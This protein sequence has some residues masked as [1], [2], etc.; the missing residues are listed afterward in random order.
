MSQNSSD[1]DR[2]RGHEGLGRSFDVIASGVG[3]VA[4]SPLLI[5]TALLIQLGTRGPVLFRQERVGRNGVPFV[6]LKFC[7][8]RQAE[9]GPAVTVSGD[10][11]VTGVG[12]FLR[13]FKLDELPQ[14]W[15]I[16][17][18]EMSVVG[19]RPEVPSY[20]DLRS[21][22]WVRVLSVSPGL[23]DP[24]TIVLRDEEGVLAAVDDP[25]TFYRE[26][27]LPFKLRFYE[28]YL[29]DRTRRSDLEVLWKTLLA[30]LLPDR[31]PGTSPTELIAAVKDHD[32]EMDRR[33]RPSDVRP[34][35]PG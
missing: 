7:S 21:P 27:L 17:R 32:P 28:S 3:L 4:L 8:M 15:N 25:E 9:R 14:L 11:R 29:D 13:R 10:R 23:T 35:R 30:V 19:P 24:V 18:G 31:R 6:M 34:G 5:L 16:L 22:Q 2:Q 26:E 33:R 20:V 1:A 12:R